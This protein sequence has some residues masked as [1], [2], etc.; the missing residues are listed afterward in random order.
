MP[1]EFAGERDRQTDRDREADIQTGRQTDR[2]AD[3]DRQ[4]PYRKSD[5]TEGNNISTT[6][7]KT[8]TEADRGLRD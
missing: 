1:V 6:G 2:P 7:T 3:R 8:R 5:Y 4:S